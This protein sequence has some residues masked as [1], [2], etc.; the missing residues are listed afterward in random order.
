[1]AFWVSV[2]VV[3]VT[4]NNGTYS[5]AAS[6][7]LDF[8]V[9]DDSGNPVFGG[10]DVQLGIEQLQQRGHVPGSRWLQ[11]AIVSPASGAT[12]RRPS[13]VAGAAGLAHHERA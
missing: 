5:F 9:T 10:A 2:S 8:S 12:G 13:G 4:D 7:N 11:R 3:V 6:I 1:M